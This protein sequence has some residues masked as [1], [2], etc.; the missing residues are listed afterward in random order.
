MIGISVKRA[1]GIGD[2]VQFSSLPE[3]YFRATG[4]KLV[5]LDESWVF[6]HNPFVLRGPKNAAKVT[7]RIDL[8][9]FSPLQ[10]HWPKP[11][12]RPESSVYQSNAEIWAAVL[13]VK[14]ELIRP[15]LYYKET[16]PF[17]YRKKILLHT[18]GR[19]HGDLPRFIVDH[20]VAKFGATKQLFLVGRP[21]DTF[22]LPYIHTETLWDLADLIS[23]CR[24]FIG[25]DSGPSWIAA[26]YPDVIV[27][28][29][30]MRPSAEAYESWTPLEI[31]N[32]HSHWDDRLFQIF[33]PTEKDVGPFQ[34]YKK[35]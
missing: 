32:F 28:K 5:D 11:L 23:E 18:D 4:S 29:V 27:K 26:C 24:M 3:N 6:D 35:M 22:G 21:K 30:R 25:S 17:E 16:F 14:A 31:K 2:V 15:R 10:Y 20:L 9:N 34:S 12:T 13:G 7:K 33:N 8:W 19:S 1:K